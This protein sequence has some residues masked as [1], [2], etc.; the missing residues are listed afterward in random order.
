MNG[1]EKIY[2]LVDAIDNA[3]TGQPLLPLY[4]QNYPIPYNL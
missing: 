1:K 4:Q 3:R 2:F